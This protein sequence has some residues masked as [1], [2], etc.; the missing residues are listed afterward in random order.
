MYKWV[1]ISQYIYE[2]YHNTGV[3]SISFSKIL[4]TAKKEEK[5]ISLP[6]R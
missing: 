6:F 2:L 4:E 5:G 1:P 3:K